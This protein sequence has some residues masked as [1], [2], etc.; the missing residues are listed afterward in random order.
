MRS[1]DWKRANRQNATEHDHGVI[2]DQTLEATP[3]DGDEALRLRRVDSPTKKERIAHRNRR[4]AQN[5]TG[6]RTPAGKRWS[7]RNALTHAVFA[8]TLLIPNKWADEDPSEY[9]A[10]LSRIVGHY[11]PSGFEEEFW[12]EKIAAELWRL[13][14]FKRYESG[15]SARNIAEYVDE[16]EHANPDLT[17]ES[18]PPRATSAPVRV[19]HLLVPDESDR[20]IRY[21]ALISRQME[22]ALTELARLQHRRREIASTTSDK[23]ST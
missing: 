20:L 14:R 19:D 15:I 8:K 2:G 22:K 9:Q 17:G 21:E 23:D 18:I 10:L 13:R 6:P 11:K 12:V 1:D 7:S 3:A 5:S 16:L 4:N